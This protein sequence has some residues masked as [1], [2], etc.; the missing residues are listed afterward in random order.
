MAFGM[1]VNIS[2]NGNSVS[3]YI[4][5]DKD[6]IT[7]GR[8]NLLDLNKEHRSCNIKLKFYREHDNELLKEA[9]KLILMAV[10]KEKNLFKVNIIVNEEMNL[11]PFLDIGF[12]LEGIISNNVFSN[13]NFKDELYLGINREEYSVSEKTHLVYIEGKNISL[14]LLTPEDAEKLLNYYNDNKS[15]LEPFEPMRDESFYTVGTQRTILN[16]SYK[17]FINGVTVDLGIYKEEKL[18]GKIKIAN[19]VQ[20][21]FKSGIVGYSIDNKNQ[22][23]GYMKEALNLLLKYAFEELELH[24][25][26]ASALVENDRSKNVLEACGFKKLGVN[27]KYL[28]INGVWRDHITYYKVK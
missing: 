20:G 6:K 3:E 5:K 25:V 23:K 13:G 24:R 17:Q 27:E 7:I 16:E 4:I 1:K 9:L 19:I 28:F 22:G 11:T 12:V 21:I 2:P 26:E 14:K 8:F 15:H 10:F 18:I